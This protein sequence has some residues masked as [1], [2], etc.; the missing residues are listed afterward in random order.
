MGESTRISLVSYVGVSSGPGLIRHFIDHYH[1]LGVDRFL[2][3]LHAPP[4]DNRTPEVL[5]ILQHYKAQPVETT[6]EFSTPRKLVRFNAIL[7]QHCEPQDWVLYADTDEFHVYPKPLHQLIAE[8]RQK[9]YEFIR[10]RLIDRVAVGGE[11]RPIT[12]SIPIFEQFA[13]VAN[14]T[15]DIR[16]GWE[17]KVCATKAT[18]RL[19]EG[20]MHTLHYGGQD[21]QINYDRT[22]VDTLGYPE[23]IDVLHFRWDSTV[24]ARL[25]NKF[26]GAAG[27]REIVDD[28]TFIA[29]YQR[30]WDHISQ[31]GC[32]GVPDAQPVGMPEVHYER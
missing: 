9:G 17:G 25:R 27:D 10:G 13:C 7:A 11:L 15:G 28:P 19:G 6:T 26:E 32:I 1:R 30:I 23:T 24:V 14:I 8:C 4:G 22:L 3:V 21:R 5:E 2:L 18:R 16:F 31:H 29:E 12:S 20:G